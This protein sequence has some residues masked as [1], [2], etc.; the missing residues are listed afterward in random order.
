MKRTLF[1][2]ASLVFCVIALPSAATGQSVEAALKSQ[3]VGKILALRHPF[4][5]KSQVYDATGKALRGGDEGPWTLYGR[6]LVKK[7]RVEKKSLVLEGQRLSYLRVDDHLAPA[8]SHEK[9][10]VQINL[11]QPLAS[12]DDAVSILG[13][14]FALTDEDVVKS[15]PRFWQNYLSAQLLHTHLTDEDTDSAREKP[16]G[17][18][19]VDIDPD[20]GLKPGKTR[21]E[22]RDGVIRP[23]PRFT[24][25]P[26]Y[27]E[28][29]R[30]QRYQGTLVLSMVIDTA[31]KVRAPTILRP[32]GMGLDEN[33]VSKILTWRFNPATVDGKPVAVLLNV[34]VAFNLY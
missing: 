16:K 33:A 6:L 10:K 8:Q 9:L 2:L 21:V 5:K 14:V 24:P 20:G 29:A 4:E 30:G 28:A 27:T 17:L 7:V 11:A 31:G 18:T 34:E 26:E 25:E 13:N 15:S 22:M 19:L 1:I 23:H 32:L 12:A 3:Y